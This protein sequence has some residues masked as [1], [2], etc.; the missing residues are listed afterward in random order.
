MLL[1]IRI[2]TAFFLLGLLFTAVLWLDARLRGWRRLAKRF[3]APGPPPGTRPARQHGDVGGGVGLFSLGRFLSA[4]AY[5][6]GLFIAAPALLRHTHPP[7][8][9]PWSQITLREEQSRLGARIIRLSIGRVHA[10]CIHLRGGIAAEVRT[11]LTGQ[12]AL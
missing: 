1:V 3:S 10:G 6:E 9:I 11:R 12:S 7:L 8:L 2:L 5:D 4:G